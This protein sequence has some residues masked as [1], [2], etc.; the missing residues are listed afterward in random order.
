M[1]K[2]QGS[3]A[4]RLWEEGSVPGQLCGVRQAPPLCGLTAPPL[5]GPGV[6]KI[7]D[8]LGGCIQLLYP[9][10]PQ[11]QLRTACERKGSRAR[12]PWKRPGPACG[13]RSPRSA[14]M[15]G[16]VHPVLH[17]ALAHTTQ[18]TS[19][20]KTSI[21]CRTHGEATGP[22]SLAV[23]WGEV[24]PGFSA[25]VSSFHPRECWQTSARVPHP[26][27]GVCHGVPTVPTPC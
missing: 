7:P 17:G 8:G 13:L 25:T 12:R 4:A 26:S 15:P 9:V 10:N 21:P 6:E 23:C 11:P 1:E 5:H 19:F 27:A 22:R 2:K 14:E 16:R 24:A 18:L 20:G 3:A